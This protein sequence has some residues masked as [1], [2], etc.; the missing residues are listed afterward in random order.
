[1]I[2]DLDYLRI[3]PTD[4][5]PGQ[6]AIKPSSVPAF[7]LTSKSLRFYDMQYNDLLI[8]ASSDGE[9]F[10]VDKF[11]FRR[12]ELQLTSEGEW[13][14]DESTGKHLSSLNVKLEGSQLGEAVQGLG[15]GNFF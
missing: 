7:M 12:D 13:K 1:M 10:K 3:D 11:N 14:F 15:F 4:A 2:I 6:T 8:N 5:E 9:T